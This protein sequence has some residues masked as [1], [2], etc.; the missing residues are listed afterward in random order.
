MTDG[1]TSAWRG[2]GVPR[3]RRQASSSSP[4]GPA[5][6]P[7]VQGGEVHRR[8]RRRRGA[9][10]P[11]VCDAAL[12]AAASARLLAS[13]LQQ[14]Y[15]D[16]GAMPFRRPLLWR[17]EDDDAAF[18]EPPHYRYG[19]GQSGARRTF[20][21]MLRTAPFD[22]PREWREQLLPYAMVDD[23]IYS[24]DDYRDA[25]YEALESSKVY[26][27]EGRER[28]DD[29]FI[30]AAFE[31]SDEPHLYSDDDQLEE[32][33]AYDDDRSRGTKGMG[34]R[35][36]ELDAPHSYREGEW[37][38]DLYS[39]EEWED[40]NS[41]NYAAGEDDAVCRRPEWHRMYHPTCNEFHAGFSTYSFLVGEEGERMREEG[42]LSRY[43]GSGHY[44]DAFLFQ[45]H[46]PSSDNMR[47]GADG[48]T[49]RHAVAWDKVVFKSMKNLY[50]NEDGMSDDDGWGYDPH[51]I[52]PF[53]YQEY[54]RMDAMVIELLHESPHAV[55]IYAHCAQSSLFE[56]TPVN[57]EDIVTPTDGFSPREFVRRRDRGK[58][59]KSEKKK[60][61]V[62]GD[63]DH[64]EAE[65]D[66]ERD[67]K[68]LNPRMSPEEKLVVALEMARCIA[69]LH[70][71]SGG[72]IAHV[73]VQLGQ[74]FV[75][76]DGKIK[77][78]DYNRAEPLLWDDKHGRY[79]GWR[80]GRP[81]EGTLRSP[82]ENVDGPI[83]E[84][85]DIYSLGNVYYSLLTG[86]RVW[87]RHEQ[88]DRIH[89]IIEGFPLTIPDSYR[90]RSAGDA[91]A[92]VIEACHEYWPEDR[93]DA[94]QLVG[95]LERLVEEHPVDESGRALEFQ[96]N[97]VVP[98]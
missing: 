55:D 12:L 22:N 38:S 79:C 10:R 21:G 72:P 54:M 33:Y 27:D 46:F 86:R 20:E 60:H 14:C 19:D 68:P 5:P 7:A 74:F 65:D 49:Q 39:E 64:N 26:P 42:R 98:F 71:H 37:R 25:T 9:T 4:A 16:D 77:L 87:E 81:A 80:N 48:K 83:S 41:G 51:D 63:G 34:M 75:G 44:R 47:D 84:K 93:P 30:E 43:L 35:Q 24:A 23:V 50:R 18:L 3:R 90:E 56:F 85:V 92:K 94:F 17:R 70:G 45:S 61:D 58:R 6:S 2:D 67:Q 13:A 1:S 96:Y 95:M 59:R 78:V 73:D 89:N 32:Y 91:L 8:Q 11:R 29:D 69:A 76:A 31:L 88:E 52:T 15:D 40:M 97:F 82:E 66:S 28:G 62:E 36:E 53:R 57:M